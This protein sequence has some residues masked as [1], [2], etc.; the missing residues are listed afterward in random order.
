[1]SFSISADNAGFA[2]ISATG[3][4]GDGNQVTARTQ[5]EFVATQA[6]NIIVDAT[7]DSIGPTGEI[8]T[9]S[10]VVRDARGIWSRVK[11][12]TFC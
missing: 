5:V 4:D 3:T 2:S 6:D 1:M 11:R 8:S 9:I 7:P 12:L 10:A